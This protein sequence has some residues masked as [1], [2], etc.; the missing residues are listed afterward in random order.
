MPPTCQP[1]QSP[2][3]AATTEHLRKERLINDV[4]RE[5]VADVGTGRTVVG[6]DVAGGPATLLVNNVGLV[7]V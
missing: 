1:S 6:V 7:G 5:P 2:G 4:A 3:V